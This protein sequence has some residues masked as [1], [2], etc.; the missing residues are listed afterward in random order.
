MEKEIFYTDEQLALKLAN[1]RCIENGSLGVDHI[2]DVSKDYL[3]FLK[4]NNTNNKQLVEKLK[5]AKRLI[6]IPSGTGYSSFLSSIKIIDEV[7]NELNK[8]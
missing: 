7:I 3:T 2:M 8:K 4:K 6:P 1:E 5:E